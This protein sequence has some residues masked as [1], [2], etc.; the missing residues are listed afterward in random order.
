MKTS[1][2]VI[3]LSAFFILSACSDDGDQLPPAIEV[4]V[5]DVKMLPYRQSNSYVGRLEAAQDVTIQAKVTGYLKKRFFAEGQHIGI[6]DKLYAIDPA[7]FQASKDQAQAEVERGEAKVKLATRN[8]E[9]GAQLIES[10]VISASQ[11]DELEESYYDSI[12]ALKSAEA[13]F[14]NALINFNDSTIIAPISGQIGKS[15]HYVGDLVGPDS[16]EL[17]T[18]VNT[19]TVNAVFSINQKMILQIHRVNINEQDLPAA[20]GIDVLIKLS[21]E[22]IYPHK[23]ALDFLDNRIDEATGTVRVTAI[24]PNPDGFL[25]HGQYVR[26]IVQAATPIDVLMIPQATVQSDQS[27]DFVL[28]VNTAKVIERAEVELGER[29]RENVIVKTGLIEGQNLILQGIQKVKVG[30]TVRVRTLAVDSAST[31]KE[32]V[33]PSEPSPSPIEE[34]EDNTS[35]PSANS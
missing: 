15:K 27:G 34:Q 28:V 2:F 10:G 17:T 6:G 16:G 22:S 31:A 12:A 4:V 19:E 26:V 30:Q 13:A 11:M 35:T 1:S 32:P 21:D 20:K 33:M 24:I 9:R 25:R 23:G 8:Y 3:L 7:T 14:D 5:S 18:I 29:V